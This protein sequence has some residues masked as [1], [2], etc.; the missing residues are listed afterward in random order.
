M[1]GL[2]YMEN[3]TQNNWFEP[4]DIYCERLS[5]DFWA[6]PLNAISNIFFIIAAFM[7]FRLWQRSA[8]RSWDLLTMSGLMA[9]VGIGSFLFHTVA[10]RWAS[11]ADVIPIA[12][13]IHFGL[14]VFLFR[15]MKLDL[16]WA[17]LGAF[18]YLV[19]GMG[20]QKVVPPEF[21]NRSGQY[22]S[23]VLLLLLI[24]IAAYIKH[25]PSAKYFLGA[26]ILFIVSLYFRS[27]DNAWCAMIPYGV[28][29]MW[30]FLNSVVMYFVFKGV[31]SYSHIDTE[32]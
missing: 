23:A 24:S 28:H 13:F 30:H 15:V 12:I 9:V 31:I 14:G 20:L 7:A 1:K 2:N 22:A 19:F 17:M 27:M 10:T 26:F 8:A 16:M 6:E 4:V 11:L 5:P 29:Y 21:F 32:A 18:L 25:V 3:A